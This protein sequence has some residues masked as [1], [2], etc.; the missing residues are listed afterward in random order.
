MLAERRNEIWSAVLD[1]DMPPA[2]VGEES[3]GDG[4][5]VFDVERREDAAQLPALSTREGKAA[6]R[7]WLA[8]NAPVVGQTKVPIWARPPIHAGDGGAMDWAEVYAQILRPNCAIAPCHNDFGAGGLAMR[9]ECGAYEALLE[10]GDCGVVR[11]EPGD[12]SSLL[13][14]KLESSEP[15]C[16]MPMPPTG[17][18]RPSDLAVVRAWV[19]GGA[20]ARNCE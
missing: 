17:P 18:L 16:K 2:R 14:D 8:C 6:L 13:L 12:A 19:E 20:P 15:A 5:W 1:G 3:Q 9:D 4:E 10:A 11:L 7:N